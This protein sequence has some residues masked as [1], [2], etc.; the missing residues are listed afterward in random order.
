LSTDFKPMQFRL[1]KDSSRIIEFTIAASSTG[2][3]LYTLRA[4]VA[5]ENGEKKTA[6]AYL[7]IDE[8]AADAARAAETDPKLSAAAGSY[9]DKYNAAPS[10]EDWRGINAEANDT[11]TGGHTEAKPQPAQFNWLLVAL[12]A[13]GVFM[14]VFYIYRKT[15]VYNELQTP[16]YRY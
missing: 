8:P 10:I 16:Y 14:I 15:H 11:L 1:G 4:I 6:E 9:G 7:T 3:N 2:H 5:D 12:A 13:A